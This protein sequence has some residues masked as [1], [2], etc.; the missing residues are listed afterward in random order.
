VKAAPY[1]LRHTFCSLLIHEG[2]TPLLV[3]A[4]MGHASGQLIWTTYGHVFVHARLAP[5]ASMVDAIE[6][7]CTDLRAEDVPRMCHATN[8]RVLRAVSGAAIK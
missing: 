2:R 7:A 4:A 6:Q 5:N 3:A 1:D 8:V